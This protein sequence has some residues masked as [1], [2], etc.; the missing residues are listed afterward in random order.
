MQLD[1]TGALEEFRVADGLDVWV[2]PD[3]A[4]SV[5]GFDPAA[6]QAALEAN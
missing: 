3:F 6:V 5:L 1:N 2:V 4:Q